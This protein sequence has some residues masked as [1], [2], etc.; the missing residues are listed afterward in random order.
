MNRLMNRMMNRMMNYPMNLHFES[1]PENFRVFCVL[2]TQ[3]FGQAPNVLW[4]F[5]FLTPP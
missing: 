4:E 5:A 3:P 2:I 1:E